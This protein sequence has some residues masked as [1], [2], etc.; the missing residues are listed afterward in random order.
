MRISA[1]SA[2]WQKQTVSVLPL[3]NTR[4]AMAVGRIKKA[5]AGLGF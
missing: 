2:W 3:R 1:Q 5:Q 4:T